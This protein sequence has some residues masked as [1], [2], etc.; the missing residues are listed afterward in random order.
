MISI[1]HEKYH[2]TRAYKI[3]GPGC[4]STRLNIIF[5][6]RMNTIKI[7]ISSEIHEDWSL[8]C[9]QILHFVPGPCSPGTS[10][11]KA[12]FVD[13]NSDKFIPDVTIASFSIKTI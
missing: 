3:D 11:I 7:Y 1:S 10:L 13:L 5:L 6:I 9:R 12:S 4:T 8:M 2:M